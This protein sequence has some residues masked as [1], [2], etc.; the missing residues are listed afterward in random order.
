MIVYHPHETSPFEW[1]SVDLSINLRISWFRPTY[2]FLLTYSYM[3]SLQIHTCIRHTGLGTVIIYT[4]I[5]QS[6]LI[7]TKT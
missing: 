3:Y 6:T 2:D 5:T 4:L 1:L 7:K